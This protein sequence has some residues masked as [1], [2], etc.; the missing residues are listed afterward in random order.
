MYSDLL[1]RKEIPNR[2]YVMCRVGLVLILFLTSFESNKRTRSIESKRFRKIFTTLSSFE[3][4]FTIILPWLIILEGILNQRVNLKNGHLLA[5]HLFVFQTQISLE[6]IIQLAGERRK[7]IMFPFTVLANIYRGVTIVT[8]IMRVVAEEEALEHRD[9]VL[10]IIALCLWLYSTFIFI[11]Y[12]WY[13]LLK[14][15]GSSVMM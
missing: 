14:D 3:V 5:A 1:F 2:D 10:P 8:W 15:E 6:C 11:P 4:V 12:E 13:P 7:W 9:V